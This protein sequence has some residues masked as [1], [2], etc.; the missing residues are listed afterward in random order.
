[1]RARQEPGYVRDRGHCRA[2]TCDCQG[3]GAYRDPIIDE[4]ALR[5]Q[6]GGD[7][8]E[9]ALQL[10]SVIRIREIGLNLHC[11]I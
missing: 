3:E 5:A 2:A 11:A 9:H 1:M 4:A 10:Q 8:L 7:L 6:G